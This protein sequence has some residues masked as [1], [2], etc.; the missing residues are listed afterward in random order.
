MATS[1]DQL[2]QNRVGQRNAVNFGR[3]KLKLASTHTSGKIV[4]HLRPGPNHQLH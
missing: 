2:R 1:V 4:K 3:A